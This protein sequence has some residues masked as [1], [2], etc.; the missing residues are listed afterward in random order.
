MDRG[1]DRIQEPKKPKREKLVSP[2][3]WRYE[4]TVKEEEPSQ[5]WKRNQENTGNKN[6]ALV[7]KGDERCAGILPDLP[8]LPRGGPHSIIRNMMF[9]PSCRL[10]NYC[11]K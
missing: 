9:N 4:S 7:E 6:I 8:L 10:T 2:I 5:P 1:N 3:S 11:E